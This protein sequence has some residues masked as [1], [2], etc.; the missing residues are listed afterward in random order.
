MNFLSFYLLTAG[1]VFV[2]FLAAFWRDNSTSKQDRLSWTI[3]LF[4][5]LFWGIVLPLAL[6]ERSRKLFRQNVLASR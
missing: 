1:L 5:A 6:V 2:V 4:G 3:I